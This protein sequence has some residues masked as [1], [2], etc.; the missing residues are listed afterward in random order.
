MPS[1][2]LPSDQQL[3]VPAAIRVAPPP[4][5]VIEDLG[6]S[7][8]GGRFPIKRI[9]GD[10]VRVSAAIHAD[11]HDRL[12]AVLRHRHED[13]GQWTE[14]PLTERGNDE[15]EGELRV[16]RTGL[17]LFTIDAWVDRFTTWR[18]DLQRRFDAGQDLSVE[19]L[20]GA[21]FVEKAVGRAGN[22]EDALELTGWAARLAG[23][24]PA[25]LRARLALSSELAALMAR[26]ADRSGSA[27]HEPPMSIR[28]DRPR[29]RFSTWY[30]MFPRSASAEPGGHG[31]FEDVERRLEHVAAMGFDVLYLPPIH[32]IG[33]AHRKGRNN[34]PRAEADDPGSP[35]AIG[36]VEGGHTDIHPRLGDLRAFRRLM[37]RAAEAGLEVAMD[38]AF[39]CS[40]D[41]PWVTEHPQWFRRAPDGT[42]RHA[43]NP[44]KTY[45]DIYPFDFQCA[46]WRALW[47]A[48]E[49]VILH[50]AREGVRIFRVDNPHTKPYAF[51][52]EAIARVQRRF[53]DTI[54]LS[55]AFTRPRVMHRLAK[56]GFTQSYT[57]FAWRT[58][59][60]E[61]REYFTEM[62]DSS[63]REYFR[64]N[65]W[66][67]T[68]DILTEQLQTGDRSVFAQRLV[69]AA[70]LGASYGIYGPAFELME[71]APRSPG[72]EEY[73]NSEKYEI[74]HWNLSAADSL[75]PLIA[76][77]NRIR[78]QHPAL[79]SDDRLEFHDVS[80]DRLLAYSKTTE[81]LMDI[82]LVVVSTDPDE[83]QSGEI[84]IPLASW[85]LSPHHPFQVHDLLSDRRSLW[86]G[87]AARVRIDP[88]AMPARILKIR[89]RVRTER[90]F[91]YYR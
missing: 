37:A 55:E 51:W 13:E 27:T 54:F 11:G 31:T 48:L 46:D 35:W 26:H 36:S 40:P 73:L 78:H 61:L 85:G 14:S 44:P 33:S 71:R 89:R 8:D 70:T 24:S 83:E 34:T 76:H 22:D 19:L 74:R 6:P 20:I 49:G 58:T 77:V 84:A 52:Q 68:P 50:W 65:L 30:E 42:I 1:R 80:N 75:R 91:D 17:H 79:Q 82:L 45:E 38:V 25:P 90:D 41:H 87:E 66:P 2:V 63:A 5:L 29:A 57:Y 12:A 39:Q 18:R 64:P 60:R 7:V 10:R 86:Q 16:H 43:E 3:A 53:P 69:L 21:A 32:P 9:V 4:R 47:N 88:R 56:A 23:G 59:A 15:W 28:V 72:E 67:N 81:D 62:R